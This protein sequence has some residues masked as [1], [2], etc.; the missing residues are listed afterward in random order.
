MGSLP[1]ITSL[2]SP[3]I[4]PRQFQRA[5]A[6]SSSFLWEVWL[7]GGWLSR[8]WGG[9]GGKGRERWRQFRQKRQRIKSKTF[10]ERRNSLKI[11][12]F[13]D[14][15]ENRFFCTLDFP[16]WMVLAHVQMFTNRKFLFKKG[17]K[18]YFARG[19]LLLFFG[20][21][22]KEKIQH[23]ISHTTYSFAYSIWIEVRGTLYDLPFLSLP[24]RDE[25][26]VQKRILSWIFRA[27][28]FLLLLF[29]IGRRRG[30]RKNAFFGRGK[31][32][33]FFLV[34]LSRAGNPFRFIFVIAEHNMFP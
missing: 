15:Y 28:Q 6:W 11:G 25:F 22:Q 33:G 4:Y 7:K 3:P 17:Q 21:H 29:P 34:P 16:L 18:K 8:P 12:D 26:F 10:C 23:Q 5:A 30:K 9:R 14:Y 20:K 32:R 27:S 13:K 31:K 1:C 2:S 19:L 24:R